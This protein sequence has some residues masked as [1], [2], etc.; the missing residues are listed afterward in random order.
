[1]A[2]KDINQTVRERQAGPAGARGGTHEEH[3]GDT[4]FVRDP[5]ELPACHQKNT[6]GVRGVRVTDLSG[7]RA[8]SVYM[9]GG[10]SGPGAV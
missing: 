7:A 4:R 10:R 3:H 6:Q 1:M 9:R 2:L 5:H 8:R